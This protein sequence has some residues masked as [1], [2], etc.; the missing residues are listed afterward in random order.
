M[1]YKSLTL[2]DIFTDYDRNATMKISCEKQGLNGIQKHSI[3]YI[4]ISGDDILRRKIKRDIIDNLQIRHYIKIGEECSICYEKILNRKTAFLTD[5]GHAFH[6]KCIIDYDFINIFNK[7][8][9][10][11]PLCR[12]DMG[13]YD[14]MKDKYKESNN[15]FDKL[16]DFETNIKLKFPKMCY[17]MNELGF[18]KHFH[19][20]NYFTCIHCQI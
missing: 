2:D 17:N 14:D 6:Y 18:N 16:E 10:Y 15:I 19:R 3:I 4:Y 13:Y 1:F 8:G 12:E 7:N 11:C 20:M 9:V 5:C